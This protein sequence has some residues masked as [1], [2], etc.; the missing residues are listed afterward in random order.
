MPKTSTTLRGIAAITAGAAI[1]LGCSADTQ[2]SNLTAPKSGN[3]TPEQQAQ[4][5]YS[6]LSAV[7]NIH[8]D[9]DKALDNK[10]VLVAA[11]KGAMQSLDPHSTILDEE[12]T[13]QMKEQQSGSFFGIGAELGTKDDFPIIIAPIEGSPAEAAGV[14]PGDM[15]LEVNGN[16]TYKMSL[17]D[18]VKQIRGERGSS[19]TLSILS[20]GAQEPRDIVITRDEIKSKSVIAQTIGTDIHYIRLTSFV[21]DDLVSEFDKA[22]AALNAQTGKTATTV[23]VDLQN[24]PGGN[25]VFAQRIADRFIDS[26]GFITYLR[27]RDGM[28]KKPEKCQ[29]RGVADNIGSDYCATPGDV[30]KGKKLYVL[31]NQGSAS[32]SEIFAGACQD[33]KR[34]TVIGATNTYGKGSAQ[35][36]FDARRISPLLS[37]MM[38]KITS[39][40]YFTP[41]GRSIQGSGITPDILVTLPE[42]GKKQLRIGTE[43]DLSHTIKNPF[44]DHLQEYKSSSTCTMRDGLDA[45]SLKKLG[46]AFV[47]NAGV[48]NYPLLCAI[49]GA[50]GGESDMANII[51]IPR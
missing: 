3:I 33:Y 28:N 12:E 44:G 25:V 43:A 22:M 1:A 13:I 35:T 2:G 29:S 38:V 30:T 5:F 36:L 4:L 6:V 31:T 42:N 17:N 39:F 15:I 26:R 40:M 46:K 21:R 10:T 14:Q 8:V 45:E 51:P 47:N 27:T 23:I 50:R 32:A 37:G 48:I 7:R 49:A 24:N 18:V 20:E 19:V 11:L 34:C 41:N 9:A 16:S